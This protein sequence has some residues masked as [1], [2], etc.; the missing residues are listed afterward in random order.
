MAS[1]KNA[2]MK[3]AQ[4]TR[5]SV[6]NNKVHVEVDEDISVPLNALPKVATTSLF[7]SVVLPTRNAKEKVVT[8][9]DINQEKQPMAEAVA[10]SKRKFEEPVA[11]PKLAAL[12]PPSKPGSK[13]KVSPA[14]TSTTPVTKMKETP[15]VKP[16]ANDPLY[17][18]GEY[19]EK[20]INW[21]ILKKFDM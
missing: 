5:S 15:I 7:K 12:A 1:R 19:S 6:R 17:N 16:S 21:S 20:L 4:G 14:Q 3:A 13:A 11:E 18:F 9:P 2:P 8:P 10:S